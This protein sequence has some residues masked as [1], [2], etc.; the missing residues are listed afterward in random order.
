LKKLLLFSIRLDVKFS[1]QLAK[2]IH[3]NIL[4]LE[5]LLPDFILVTKKQKPMAS[6]A[7][8]EAKRESQD[9]GALTALVGF[10]LF[11]CLNLDIRI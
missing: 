7:V 5:R 6:S 1:G 11:V 3:Q 4:E 8:R 2:F 9:T 10:V